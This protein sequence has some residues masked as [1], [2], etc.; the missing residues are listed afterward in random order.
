[1]VLRSLLNCDVAISSGVNLMISFGFG[2]GGGKFHADG[3]SIFEGMSSFF[4]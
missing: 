4:D 1:M 3:W 2:V